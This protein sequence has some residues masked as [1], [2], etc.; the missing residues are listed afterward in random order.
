LRPKAS[1]PFQFRVGVHHLVNGRMSNQQTV[2]ILY[3]GRWRRFARLHL[4]DN[5]PQV[6][7]PIPQVLECHRETGR[8][9][10]A[11]Q[12]NC[13][14]FADDPRCAEPPR[15]SRTV[16]QHLRELS[17]YNRPRIDEIKRELIT[18]K[19]KAVSP[20]HVCEPT[21]SFLIVNS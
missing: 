20:V 1:P 21:V 17:V 9:P 3:E 18:E 2:E 16:R 15:Q 10:L 19:Q 12:T 8:R 13:L 14:A 5:L 7:S 4:Q 11:R 6:L